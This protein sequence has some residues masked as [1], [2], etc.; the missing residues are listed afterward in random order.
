MGYR[1]SFGTSIASSLSQI[2][3]ILIFH[4]PIFLHSFTTL[5]SH[6]RKLLDDPTK[7]IILE[8]ELDGGQPSQD[9]G[10]HGSPSKDDEEG[11]KTS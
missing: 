2:F 9:F 1:K 6:L 3:G 5:P 10:S 7:D 8:A 4:S 11:V